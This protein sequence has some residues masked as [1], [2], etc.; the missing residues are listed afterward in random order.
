MARILS[1]EKGVKGV[2]ITSVQEKSPAAALRLQTGDVITAV[3]GTSVSN[4]KEFYA[5][6]DTQKNS[7]VYFDVYSDGHTIS[8][9][10]YRIPN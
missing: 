9:A 5:A 10:R 8:T 3:N 1:V 2:V 4:V 6:L 7:Q